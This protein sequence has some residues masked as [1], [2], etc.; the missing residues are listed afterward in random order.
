MNEIQAI[1]FTKS[2]ERCMAQPAFLDRFYARFMGSAP[3]IAAHF[4]DTDF[5]KQKN[6]LSSSLYLM[7]MA[8]QGGDAATTYLEGVA[9]RHSRADLD[10]APELYDVWLECLIATA[11]D[12]DPH[13]N[14]DVEQSW[15]QTLQFGID[16]MRERY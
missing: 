1:R 4:R 10:I 15:R 9:R 5:T 11:R 6:A 8:I 12:H 2:L 16:F 14:G 7:V 3:E 13:F